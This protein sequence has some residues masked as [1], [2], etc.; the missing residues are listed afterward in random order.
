MFIHI[1]FLFN[2]MYNSSCCNFDAVISNFFQLNSQLKSNSIKIEDVIIDSLKKIKKT[3]A[4]NAYICINEKVELQAKLSS[5]LFQKGIYCV[6]NRRKLASVNFFPFPIFL[7]N[8]LGAPKSILE[9]VPI[10]V[11][12][13]FCVKDLPTTCGSKML[14]NFVPK[15]TATV[16]DKLFK[17]GALVIGKTNMDEF[18]MGSGTTT[19]IFGPT[20]NI[21]GQVH[22]NLS[23][24]NSDDWYI[25]G[26][27]SGGSA[28]AVAS[29][30]C[31]G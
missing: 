5:Q 24:E 10:A 25:S 7:F 19:S 28:V 29:G 13:N 18:G 21:W 31:Y 15:Y 4:L 17:A 30:T 1:Y 23:T 9:G 6:N 2:F 22:P 27:S 12:D 14:Q 8:I 16:V 3:A 26:G 11:K 20:K